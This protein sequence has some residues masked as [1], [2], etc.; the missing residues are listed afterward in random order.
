M[1]TFV[2]LHHLSFASLEHWS[3]SLVFAKMKA[4]KCYSSVAC[5][6]TAQGSSSTAAGHGS[7][8]LGSGSTASAVVP[9]LASGSTVASGPTLWCERM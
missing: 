4:S 7:T 8:A 3:F 2:P 6:S 5:G 9:L 1:Y